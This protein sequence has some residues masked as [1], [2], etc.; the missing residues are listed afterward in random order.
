M[1]LTVLLFAS[2]KDEVGPTFRVEVPE[3]EAGLARVAALRKSLE[4]AHPAFARFGRRA[5]VAVNEAYATDG[6]PLRA[7][8][9]VAVLPPVAGG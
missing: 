5:L 7:G 9:T 4:A 1:E 3:E 6:D 2:L 8:D